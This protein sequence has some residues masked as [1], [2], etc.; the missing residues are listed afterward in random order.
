METSQGFMLAL[1]W[2]FLRFGLPVLITS[3]IIL[4]LSQ[5]DSNWKQ[6]AISRTKNKFNK[7]VI[8]LM[9]C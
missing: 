5:I 3:L 1:A 6:E 4:F 7:G 2:V 8:P 9:K